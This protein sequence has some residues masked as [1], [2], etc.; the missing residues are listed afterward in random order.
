MH[1]SRWQAH[2]NGKC[3]DAQHEDIQGRTLGPIRHTT[4]AQACHR[5]DHRASSPPR[6]LESCGLTLEIPDVLEEEVDD[7]LLPDL[8]EINVRI[9]APEEPA[10]LL[11]AAGANTPAPPAG[12][13]S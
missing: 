13:R 5:E 8:M 1:C 10:D 12:V 9:N 3:V 7:A 11:D 2:P 4:H 6:V